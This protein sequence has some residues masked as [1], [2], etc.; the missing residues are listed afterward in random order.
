MT[1]GGFLSA[2]RPA[3]PHVPMRTL[4][5]YSCV[6][7]WC[8]LAVGDLQCGSARPHAPVWMHLICSIHILPLTKKLYIFCFN[9]SA[10][11]CYRS[12]VFQVDST[13]QATESICFTHVPNWPV[14]RWSY[15]LPNT[16]NM[17]SSNPWLDRHMISYSCVR[18]CQWTLLYRKWWHSQS[19]HQPWFAF[20]GT[21]FI[22]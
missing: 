10:H 14:I 19:L 5:V 13:R 7:I 4:P 2:C 6:N 22:G 9:H 8:G 15:I 21:M 16:V 12:R 17:C 20:F 11:L 18:I 3:R 1:L